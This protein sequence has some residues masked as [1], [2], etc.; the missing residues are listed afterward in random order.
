MNLIGN[1]K[2]TWRYINTYWENRNS[3]Q[4]LNFE[5]KEVTNASL[6][7]LSQGYNLSSQT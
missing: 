6:V 7:M 4:K 3:K 1:W 2:S 5:K